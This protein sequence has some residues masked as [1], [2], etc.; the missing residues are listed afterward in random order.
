M[1]L[2]TF[3]Y[4]V[5]TIFIY[6]ANKKSANAANA[7]L[8]QNSQI[9]KQNA[10]IQL[11]NDR[12]DLFMQVKNNLNE[13]YNAI[14]NPYQILEKVLSNPNYSNDFEKNL[15]K[16]QHL[17]SNKIN[18]NLQEINKILENL[19]SLSYDMGKITE[20]I[21]NQFNGFI[22]ESKVF[23]VKESN[24]EL[25]QADIDN[26]KNLCSKN[27]LHGVSIIP[28]E[29]KTYNFYDMYEKYSALEKKYNKEKDILFM[30]FKKELDI[31]LYGV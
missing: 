19:S 29:P 2:L 18:N 31:K 17:F 15:L 16:A 8:D 24:N 23:V 1:F 27:T 14:K 10:D 25:D 26:F 22:S 3:V 21:E 7:I 28:N 6:R 5:A 20:L 13:K 9:Q 4:V 11:F 12:F 30:Q